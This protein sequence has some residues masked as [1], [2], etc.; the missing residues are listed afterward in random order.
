MSV[1][2]QIFEWEGITQPSYYNGQILAATGLK[3]MDQIVATGANTVTIIP[4]FFQANKFSNAVWL[5]E[6]DPNNQ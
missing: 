3:A 1:S 5:H 4:N 2:S 6:G